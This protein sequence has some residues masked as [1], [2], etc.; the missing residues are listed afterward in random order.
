MTV[1]IKN[2][3]QFATM[4]EWR[5]S[6]DELSPE[7]YVEPGEVL[8]YQGHVAGG[9]VQARRGDSQII[10]NPLCTVELS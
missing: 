8:Q 10:I 2:R 4:T 3:S 1:T 7:N 5:G 9:M 6:G